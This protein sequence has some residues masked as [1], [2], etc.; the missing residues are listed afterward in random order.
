MELAP[1]PASPLAPPSVHHLPPSIPSAPLFLLTRAPSGQNASS[2]LVF[3]QAGAGH[4]HTHKYR[5]FREHR[6]V[7]D[8][9]VIWGIPKLVWVIMLDVA[10]LAIFTACLPLVMYLAKKRRPDFERP[11]ADS[12]GWCGWG[13]S[14]Q[15][16][17]STSRAPPEYHSSRINS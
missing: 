17:P 2:P 6:D 5:Y 14:P 13:S 3:L 10:A 7:E 9:D 11:N 15:Q 12:S 8:V 16:F 4:A 1:W